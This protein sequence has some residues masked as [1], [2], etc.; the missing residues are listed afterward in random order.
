MSPAER[1]SGFRMDLRTGLFV[2]LLVFLAT[3]CAMGR[4]SRDSKSFMASHDAIRPGM[5]CDSDTFSIGEIGK[6]TMV[7]PIR[8][9]ST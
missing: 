7:S 8:E 6:V 2:A 5:S 3:S 4:N 1:R 9:A